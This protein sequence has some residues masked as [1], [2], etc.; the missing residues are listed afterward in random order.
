LADFRALE[1]ALLAGQLKLANRRLQE[2]QQRLVQLERTQSELERLETLFKL[3]FAYSGQWKPVE[4]LLRQLVRFLDLRSNEDALLKL[5]R[6]RK[7]GAPGKEAEA[8]RVA[9]LK[10]KMSWTK[11][12]LQMNKETNTD[13]TITAYRMKYY[14]NR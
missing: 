13:R 14:R 3:R 5:V 1:A 10:H 9:E 11:L 7:K 8:I 6:R 12:T 4:P 2:S